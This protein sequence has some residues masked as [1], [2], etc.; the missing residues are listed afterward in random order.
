MAQCISEKKGNYVFFFSSKQEK[1]HFLGRIFNEIAIIVVIVG[2][3][4]HNQNEMAVTQLKR[5]KEESA[6]DSAISET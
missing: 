2:C 1:E 3:H 6:R 5:I 4:H